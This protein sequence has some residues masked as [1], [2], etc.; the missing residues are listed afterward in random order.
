MICFD[1]ENVAEVAIQQSFESRQF[2]HYLHKLGLACLRMGG[3][4]GKVQSS[5]RDYPRP[6][7]SQLTLKYMKESSLEMPPQL[8]TNAWVSSTKSRIPAHLTLQPVSNNRCW[9]FEAPS[10]ELAC[11]ITITNWHID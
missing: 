4:D 5:Q 6:A 3:H 2:C 9:W 7:D 10:L 11:S 8:T 1:Q